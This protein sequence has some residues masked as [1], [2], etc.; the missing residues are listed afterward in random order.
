MTTSPEDGMLEHDEDQLQRT[1]ERGDDLADT[2]K[3]EQARKSDEDAGDSPEGMQ[4]SD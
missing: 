1:A 2:V 4:H 3:R